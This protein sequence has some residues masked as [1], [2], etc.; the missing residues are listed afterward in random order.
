[1]AGL[2]RVMTAGAAAMLVLLSAC[3]RAAETPD[4]AAPPRASDPIVIPQQSSNIAVDL[5]VDLADLEAALERELPRELWAID[6]P[7]SQ[8]VP[9]KKVD[10]EL[11]ELKTPTIKCRIVGKVTRGKLRLTGRGEALTVT[12]PVRG[13]LAARDIAGVLKGETG[14]GAA[15]AA[16]SLKLDLTPEW[17]LA[18][19]TRLDYRWTRAPGIDFLGRRITFT[20]K[21]DAELR[22]IKRQI[23]TIIARELAHLPVKAT[24]TAGWREAHDVFNL[25]RANPAVWGRI[26]PERF[27]FGGYDVAGRKLTLRLGLDAQ[28]ETFVG[29]RP[30]PVAPAPLPALARRAKDAPRS[31]LHIPVIADYAVLEPVIAKALAERAARPFAIKD[32]GTVTASFDQITVYGTGDGLIAVGGRFAAASDLPLIRSAK[33][34]IWLTAKPVN[35]PGS[36]KVRFVDVRITGATDLAGDGFLFAL[37]NSPEVRTTITDA[38]AQNF[39]NDFA[40]L[41]GKID[42]ALAARKGRLTDYTIAIEAIDTGVIRAHGKG[43]YLPVDVTARITAR[44]R[45]LD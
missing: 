21:A 43:L 27:R 25:N 35:D 11:F 15:E 24:A 36:R 22:P 3:S 18:G 2:R 38:L 1:M 4:G 10:L 37:A 33:G 8:C 26:T 17:K 41:R 30:D 39:E 32:Y 13:T 28:L 31:I 19:T 20:S 44:L 16:L 34:M 9:S 7:E 40:K 42:T 5:A 14:T 23:E 45:K 12:L 6:Q 29:T